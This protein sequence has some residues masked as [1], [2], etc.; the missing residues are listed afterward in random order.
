MIS[1][2][3]IKSGPVPFLG[4]LSFKPYFTIE[5]T[6]HKTKKHLRYLL[7]RV[8]ARR[9]VLM[10]GKARRRIR[11]VSRMGKMHRYKGV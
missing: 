9:R 4:L 6:Q 5:K 8:K 2:R 1:F 7:V 10:M 11:F 3:K